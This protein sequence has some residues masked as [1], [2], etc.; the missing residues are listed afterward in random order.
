MMYNSLED[1]CVLAQTFGMRMNSKRDALTSLRSLMQARERLAV[2][3]WYFRDT[4]MMGLSPLPF[5]LPVLPLP[6]L[7]VSFIDSLARVRIWPCDCLLG[8]TLWNLQA[9]ERG[10][11]E[12]KI[13]V[14]QTAEHS[15]HS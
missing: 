6:L 14:Q 7:P 8:E 1:A 5:S 2:A 10:C 13:C 12:D 3:G 11:L 4:I 9:W 15:C